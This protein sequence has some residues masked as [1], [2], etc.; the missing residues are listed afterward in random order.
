MEYFLDHHMYTPIGRVVSA[1][2]AQFWALDSGIHPTQL[3]ALASVSPAEAEFFLIGLGRRPW[4]EVASALYVR[5]ALLEGTLRA[6][7]EQLFDIFDENNSST[8][9]SR[10]LRSCLIAVGSP[11]N[12]DPRHLAL[13]VRQLEMNP[14]GTTEVTKEEFV[15]LMAPVMLIELD[16][17]S[18]G[19]ANPLVGALEN[20][21]HDF[22]DDST[23]SLDLG[24][25]QRFIQ[26]ITK[27]AIVKLIRAEISLLF[28][29]ADINGD[30]EVDVGEFLDGFVEWLSG[31]KITDQDLN[32]A[33]AKYKLRHT[34]PVRILEAAAAFRKLPSSCRLA[35]SLPL[36]CILS[37]TLLA[38]LGST[39][40]DAASGLLSTDPMLAAAFLLERSKVEMPRA[41]EFN[42]D[43]SELPPEGGPG[44]PR[45]W[46]AFFSSVVEKKVATSRWSPLRLRR[47]MARAV[48]HGTEAHKLR[49][50]LASLTVSGV[51]GVEP[52]IPCEARRLRFTW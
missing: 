29:D 48:L 18:V 46:S 47:D 9:D 20:I 10:E 52:S 11:T 51:Q 39:R 1:D 15:Q 24:E 40:M 43:K 25:F 49:R 38:P 13:W 22:D 3:A 21:F 35:P 17:F 30:G 27:D 2:P 41:S 50:S 12:L 45:R 16:W 34:R 28:N 8:I 44:P 31:G 23:G 14:E 6:P 37:R 33:L 19:Q 4:P 32:L 26:K 7:L 36:E 42:L 5:R